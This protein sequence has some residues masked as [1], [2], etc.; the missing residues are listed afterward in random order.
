MDARAEKTPSGSA[1]VAGLPAKANP[2]SM[3]RKLA[4]TKGRT[5]ENEQWSPYLTNGLDGK[6]CVGRDPMT[7][8]V[9][10]LTASG[11]PPRRTSALVAAFAK[12]DG[13]DLV[14]RQDVREYR[15]I[16]RYVCLPCVGGN[17][18]EVRRCTTI[19]W[20]AVIQ[21]KLDAFERMLWREIE[22]ATSD[23]GHRMHHSMECDVICLEAQGR[24]NDLH[25]DADEIYRFRLGNR[26]RLW[27]FR[28][29]NRFE[30]LWY[31]PEHHIYPT[32]PD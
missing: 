13:G 22:A 21:P 26:R 32:D 3:R 14:W 25:S 24:L 6:K 31:D 18:A 11:H 28:I 15:D 10:V 17:D 8:P 27:G 19:N 16:R 9:E 7:I 5:A 2:V 23:T 30:I 29:T 20:K 12:A 1:R 4:L